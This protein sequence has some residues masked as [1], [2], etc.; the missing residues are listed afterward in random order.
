MAKHI[1]IMLLFLSIVQTRE[2]NRSEFNPATVNTKCSLSIAQPP[3]KELSPALYKGIGITHTTNESAVR[4][5]SKKVIIDHMF[6]LV[7]ES[8]EKGIV[9]A[10]EA[11]GKT[12]LEYFK[13]R[14]KDIC[15]NIDS[16]EFFTPCHYDEKMPA[17]EM[18]LAV[19]G[20]A[21]QIMEYV[22]T[23]R[24]S[25]ED[26][27]TLHVDTTG[28]M[29]HTNMMLLAVM[30]LLQ[31]NRVEIGDILYSD[32]ER[33]R[34]E[35]YVER[36]NNV[37]GL[38]NVIAGAE[39]FVRSG[40]VSTLNDYFHA[41]DKELST[42]L[43][44]LLTAMQK[45]SQEIKL[46]HRGSFIDAATQLKED[47]QTFF[48][49]SKKTSK[50]TRR[51]WDALM[52]QIEPRLWGDY[53]DL[54]T[55]GDINIDT[56]SLIRWCLK[57][58]HLQQALTLYTESMPAYW[59]ENGFVVI[60]EC[61]TK[62]AQ[63]R[64]DN[65]DRREPI[66]WL[67]TSYNPQK[68]KQKKGAKESESPMMQ[69][70]FSKE[71]EIASQDNIARDKAATD[72]K[73]I[74]CTPLSPETVKDRLNNIV[75]ALKEHHLIIRN[76]AELRAWIEELC[77]AKDCGQGTLSAHQNSVQIC[78]NLIPELSKNSSIPLPDGSAKIDL[79]SES[80]PTKRIWNFFSNLQAKGWGKY[81]C[82]IEREP[83]FK[84]KF[85]CKEGF[86]ETPMT[87]T[88]MDTLIENY[89]VLRDERNQ[90]NH[91]RTDEGAFSSAEC[92]KKYMEDSLNSI[93]D[94]VKKYKH[95]QPRS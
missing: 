86:I 43:S 39:E 93:D 87:D 36:I 17:G 46:C 82:H 56:I 50:D 75:S 76:E 72:L 67:L 49:H 57:N 1:N 64:M 85:L 55:S 26:T 95:S 79:C 70:L 90:V 32:Y 66:F 38:F 24:T 3:G 94:L 42:E 51:Q 27:I 65:E 15:P 8:V 58:D 12:H 14:I 5:L 29:R 91:A 53:R 71:Q 45:F 31:Y 7:T 60:T 33:G 37:Y 10:E 20:I 41:D 35:N 77:A 28:G 13:H 2:K 73:K 11:L 9:P 47:M 40:S 21:D 30:R 78:R 4:Y 6:A 44:N 69:E 83:S 22:R 68:G 81:L 25:K 74:F 62:M 54:I 80:V 89:Q 16:K 52:A 34:A 84:L 19:T 88:E 18:L 63:T 92:L 59:V 48:E 61:G 23:A